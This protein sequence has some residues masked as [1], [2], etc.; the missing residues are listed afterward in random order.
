[1]LTKLRGVF[2]G[3]W[4]VVASCSLLFLCGGTALY[5]FSAFFDPI[6]NEMGW[7]RAETSIAFSLKSVE[8]GLVAPLLGFFVDRIGSRKS[9]FVGLLIMGVSLFLISRLSDLT[10]FYTGFFL[11]ALG[12]TFASGIP[13]YTAIAAWFRKRR[14][15]AL[16]I[17]TAG[18][19]AS[20]ILTPVITSA[21]DTYGWRETLVYMAPMVVAIG[22]PL[23]LLIRRRPES[24]GLLPD[25]EKVTA[26]KT[27]A[28]SVNSAVAAADKK[29]DG[30]TIRQCL[31]TRTFWF[32]L[33]YSLFTSFASSAVQV[34]LMPHL[35]NVGISRDLAA[36]AMTG[37]TVLSLIGRLGLSWLGDKYS[38]KKL[39]IL[40]AV[41]QAIGVAVLAFVNVPWMIIPFLAFYAPGF[42]GPIPLLP[43]IQADFFGT[44]A[45]A[46]VRGM[47]ALGYTIP[48]IIAPWVAG[49]I[50]D[51][52]GSYTLAFLICAGLTL[53]AIP[54]MMMA[55]LTRA[56]A[57]TDKV[58]IAGVH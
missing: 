9:I 40:S 51:V 56:G 46:S 55:T 1:M 57:A 21:I 6:Y 13:E 7:S 52:T 54:V 42:G 39:L 14:A 50:C 37:Y 45:F 43:A 3:W 28:A 2:Y 29:D 25:G 12:N 53:L 41:L 16:G 34:H 35:V 44:K 5:G 36:L 30:L 18:M 49:L 20:G 8:S 26:G 47:M 22:V 33:M 19:G 11:L 48:G 27:D 24:Y 10:S 23:S 17:L 32:L 15:L 58:E 31:R 38:K 4:I